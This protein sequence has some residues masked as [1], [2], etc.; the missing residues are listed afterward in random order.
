MHGYLMTGATGFLGQEL[1]VDLLQAGVAVAV[2]ARGSGRQSAEDRIDGLLRRAEERLGRALPRPRVIAGRLE[3]PG[4][5]LSQ[6]ERRWLRQNL[7]GVVHVAASVSFFPD[8]RGDPELTNLT[9]TERI[10]NLC[11]ELGWSELHHVSTAYVAGTRSGAIREQVEAE[12]PSIYRNA[13][14]SSKAAAERL[15]TSA[16]W[17]R[18]WTI[19]RP[20]VI[21]GDSRTAE[22]T[23]FNGL[24]GMIRLVWEHDRRNPITP[25][26]FRHW[27]SQ[28]NVTQQAGSN[29][30]PVDWVSAAMTRLILSP[31]H[32]GGVYHLTATRPT[33]WSEIEAAVM[34]AVIR[35]RELPRPRLLPGEATQSAAY[36]AMATEFLQSY[37]PYFGTHP[38]FISERVQRALPDLL[39]PEITSEWLERTAWQA[40]VNEFRTPRA[41]QPVA[42]RPAL[43]AWLEQTVVPGPGSE[44]TTQEN[45]RPVTSITSAVERSA[46]QGWGLDLSGSGGGRYWLE[47]VVNSRGD[48]HSEQA[49]PAGSDAV[50]S[51]DTAAKGAADRANLVTTSASRDRYEVTPVADCRSRGMTWHTTTATWWR[52]VADPELVLHCI[53]TGQLLLSWGSGPQRDCRQ[54]AGEL[55]AWLRAQQ[56]PADMGSMTTIASSTAAWSVRQ[57]MTTC[58]PSEGTNRSLTETGVFPGEVTRTR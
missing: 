51:R 50:E 27:T 21:V 35:S 28:W 12:A 7:S 52:L 57:T 18:D 38:Q 25:E 20:S 13:Y 40:I 15:V 4:C 33:L 9:G 42:P 24:Y 14:E 23:G 36:L 26:L 39:V 8:D 30:V 17:L 54:A 16:D 31:R 11:R 49:P 2:L 53:Q 19:Y 10:L 56:A 45:T 41:T 22:A 1:L 48:L 55:V 37:Q 32:H 44:V 34:Q 58:D 29:L 5:G 47:P 43:V 3:E 46:A 6:P